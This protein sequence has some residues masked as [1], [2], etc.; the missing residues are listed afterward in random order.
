MFPSIGVARRTA[1]VA[2]ALLL[3]CT[4]TLGHAQTPPPDSV[5][6]N[7]SFEL[8]PAYPDAG[9]EG[10]SRDAWLW[11]SVLAWDGTVAK[12][13]A[14]SV[15]ITADTPNDARWTQSLQLEPNRNYLL[16]GWI[17]TENVVLP[18]GPADR[19]ANLS[20]LYTWVSTPAISGTQDWTYVSVV[21]NSGPS[22]I[23]HVAARLGFYG[24]LA[25]GT[26]W[27]DD[28]RVRPILDT[29]PFPRWKVLV[30]IYQGTELTYT[31]AWGQRREVVGHIPDAQLAAAA[32][33]ATRF[34]TE[35]VPALTSGM[36][37]PELTIRYP[38]TL[39]NL[40]S[41]WGGF[42]PA[43]WDTTPDRDPAFDSVFVIWQPTVTDRLTGQV[44]WI[45]NAGGLAM[46]MGTSQTYAAVIVESTTNYAN[47]NVFKHEWG[48]SILFYYDAA[49]T[50]P[51]PAVNNHA[52]ATTYVNC[53]TGQPYVWIDE[54]DLN[55]I[56]NSI[57]HNTSGFTHDYYSGKTALADDPA[58]CLGIN[59]AAWATGGPVTKPYDDWREEASPEDAPGAL[60][61]LL[62]DLVARG[63]LRTPWSQPL[64]AALRGLARALARGDHTQAEG[65]LQLFERHVEA[66][67]AKGRLQHADARALLAAAQAVR[68]GT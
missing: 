13:G 11:T 21:F 60:R 33:E 41:L 44:L 56:P 27:F 47:R 50:A 58:R 34:F 2:A 35:D 67:A 52:E 12:D 37:T 38:G 8:G 53:E 65:K 3:A 7:G 5:L 51:Q 42:W 32:R 25:S 14:A 63:A 36:M 40:S 28:V 22:G 49:G 66:L 29:P 6:P 20:L 64:E 19:G 55:P 17:K 16:S 9:P 10:W 61:S 1:S 45:G 24:A 31:D 23:V 18:D 59:A 48:H 57:Y 4:V 43:P 62:S 54:T 68:R 46:P 39:R 30:L 15:G 26:A